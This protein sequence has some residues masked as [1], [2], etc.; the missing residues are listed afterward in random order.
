MVNGI[1][2]FKDFFAEYKEQYVLIGGAACDIILEESDESFRATKDLDLVLIVEALTPEFGEAFWQFIVNGG[3]RNKSKSTG[4]PQFYRFDKPETAGYPYML[5]LFSKE[6]F[7]LKEPDSVLTPLHFSE[8]ISSLSAILLNETYYNMLL[9][10][11]TEIDNLVVL[12]PAYIIP[13]KAKAWLDLTDKKSKGM[14]VDEKDIKKHKNDIVR[15]TAIL[16][17]DEAVN[18]PSEVHNDMEQFISMYE[19]SPADLKSLH[20]VG[21][22]NEQIVERLREIYLQMK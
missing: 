18:L 16:I 3:Y 8:E 15:L 12:A 2:I 17:G 11:R 19:K 13:F 20:I 6:A 4:S 9:T 14:H 1:E 7:D 10:G 22:S 21:V 5:E